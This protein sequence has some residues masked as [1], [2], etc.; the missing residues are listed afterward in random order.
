MKTEAWRGWFDSAALLDLFPQ[1][2]EVSDPPH[3]RFRTGARVRLVLMALKRDEEIGEEVHADHD[4][5]FRIEKG[6]GE[7]WIDGKRTKIK[8]GA[9]ILVLG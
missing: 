4:Q 2:E 5:F 1:L 3:K 8:S 9:A 6:K 7:V